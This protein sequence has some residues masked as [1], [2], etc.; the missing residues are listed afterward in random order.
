MAK[1]KVPPPSWKC[2]DLADLNLL[3]FAWVFFP[4]YSATLL[5][6]FFSDLLLL[7]FF[8]IGED[9]SVLTVW[10]DMSSRGADLSGPVGRKCPTAV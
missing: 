6:L 3:F 2:T 8:S 7:V 4:R 10:T 9:R 5:F 1:K